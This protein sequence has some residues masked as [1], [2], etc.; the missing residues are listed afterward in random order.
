MARIV[1]VSET[2]S[3]DPEEYVG[4]S[5]PLSEAA[6]ALI[7]KQRKAIQRICK[8]KQEKAIAEK[9]FLS[10]RGSVRV[11][12]ILRDCPDIGETIA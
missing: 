12:K 11:S 4:V 6:K 5:E 8:R 7:V 1:N 10:R 3:D 9:H 2:D